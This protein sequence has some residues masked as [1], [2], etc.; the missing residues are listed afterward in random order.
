MKKSFLVVSVFYILLMLFGNS[1]FAQ[2]YPK[3]ELTDKE[4]K[5]K[6]KVVPMNATTAQITA[7]LG[8]PDRN[9]S[10]AP[11]GNA[12]I[13]DDY[14]IR[15]RWDGK[16]K[17]IHSIILNVDF[18]DYDFYPD[19]SYDGDLTM[20]GKK[21]TYDTKI[22]DFATMFPGKLLRVSDDFSFMFM[23]LG[24]FTI[25]CNYDWNG[26]HI[27]KAMTELTIYP[28]P[29][30]YKPSK[31]LNMKFFEGKFFLDNKKATLSGYMDYQLVNDRVLHSTPKLGEIGAI[32]VKDQKAGITLFNKYNSSKDEKG[33]WNNIRFEVSNLIELE[34][35]DEAIVL[36][37]EY[38]KIW[39]KN[40]QVYYFRGLAYLR[41]G[42]ADKAVYNFERSVYFNAG[43][44]PWD[45]YKRKMAK[46][47]IQIMKAELPAL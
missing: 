11:Y 45:R 10:F 33:Q 37:D 44:K 12:Y 22:S 17:G 1:T 38:L 31:Y 16:N 18:G 13:Y 46:I 6:G 20:N 5:I 8:K 21:V 25:F 29:E 14:G 4:L 15:V 36:C 3:I 39:Q 30:A 34:Y 27:F 2:N 47:Y 19:E 43:K 26:M 42:N 32:L 23:Q 41:K 9:Y 35:Y 24:Q 28:R 40:N 7:I